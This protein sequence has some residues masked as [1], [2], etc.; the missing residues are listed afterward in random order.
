MGSTSSLLQEISSGGSSPGIAEILLVVFLTIF[1]SGGAFYAVFRYW[2][3]R[4]EVKDATRDQERQDDKTER[5]AAQE[6]IDRQ[7]AE[8]RQDAAAREDR[9]RIE[10]DAREQ[11]LIASFAER[12]ARTREHYTKEVERAYAMADQAIAREREW[13]EAVKDAFSAVSRAGVVVTSA[14]E[15]LQSPKG[16]PDNDPA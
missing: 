15:R 12:D 3:R 2:T 7:I 14:T 16:I 13:V 5:L 6:R 4:V 9:L 11:R 1:G 10:A 8:L